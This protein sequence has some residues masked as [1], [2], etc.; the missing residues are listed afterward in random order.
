MTEIPEHL[1]QRSRD[2]RA[3]LGL[4]GGDDA[5]AG[6]APAAAAASD[7]GAAVT[8]A[9]S[10]APAPRP[11][12]T[13]LEP[14]A[15]EPEPVPHYVE[16]SQRRKRIP[17]FAIP[18]LAG[19]LAWAPIYVGTLQAPEATGG[20]VA[21]GG[22]VYATCAGCHGAGGGGGVGRPL[23]GGEVLLTFPDWQSHYEF[24]LLGNQ[25]DPDGTVYGDPERP[26]G[27]H[28]SGEYNGQRMPAF[29]DLPTVEL[30][31]V[32]LYERVTHGEADMESEDILSLLEA[33]EAVQGGEELDMTIDM[34]A[35]EG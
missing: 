32:V 7:T 9:A 10:S 11:K 4:G 23:A 22:E 29:P 8:P 35:G 5:G 6:A 14:V 19:I 20:P 34:A 26:G 15:K 31:E 13:P 3:A 33:I 2:R 28:R 24:V 12:A 30:L 1:L 25:G 16:A 18:I 27:P 21:A 17:V